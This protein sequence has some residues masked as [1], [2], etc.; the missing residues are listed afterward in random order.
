MEAHDFDEL[1][2][3]EIRTWDQLGM[4]HACLGWLLGQA[5]NYQLIIGTSSEPLYKTLTNIQ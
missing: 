5:R 3:D 1:S 4:S 2:W